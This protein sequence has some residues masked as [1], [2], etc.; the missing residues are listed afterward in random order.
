MKS[1]HHLRKAKREKIFIYT[2]IL[3]LLI[4]AGFVR[5]NITF[6]QSGNHEVSISPSPNISPT[7]VLQ[8]P[9]SSKI[10]EGNYHI[11]QTFNNCGPA[12]LSMALSYYGITRSQHTL[13][14]ELRPFQNP[15]GDND[16]KSVT[17]DELAKKSRDYGFIPYHRPN[18]DFELIKYFITYDIPVIA[19]TWLKPDEDIGHYRVI[20]GYDSLT[21]QITQD[22]SLQGQNLTY[23]YDEFYTL[24]EKFNFEYLVLVPLEKEEI[25]KNILGENLDS[26]KAWKNAVIQSQERLKENPNNIYD[27]FNLSVAFY[28]TAEFQ[29]SVEEFEKIENQLPFRTLWYQIE[30]IKAYYELENFDRVFEITDKILNNYNRAF[31]ELYLLRGK[32]YEK[33]GNLESAKQEFEKAV[34][35]NKNLKS[36]IE[37]LD[38]I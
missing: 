36:A 21:N 6:Q 38:K 12:A 16:D 28:N 9:S 26:K 1:R 33:Q 25:A 8:I 24:W 2:L 20:K 17:L 23:S 31:S 37:A 35:Y 29:K 32:I 11:Y 18:G 3:I 27:R 4:I 7:P 5:E 30:P 10:L 22:D 19:R 13:G 34:F 14:Q 15:Q